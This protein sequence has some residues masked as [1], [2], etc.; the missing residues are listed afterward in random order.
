MMVCGYYKSLVDKQVLVDLLIRPKL[1]DS[2][3]RNY[4]RRA[5]DSIFKCMKWEVFIV[6]AIKRKPSYEQLDA[7]DSG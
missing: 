4:Q 1:P 5:A 7:K 6:K 2:H 3:L